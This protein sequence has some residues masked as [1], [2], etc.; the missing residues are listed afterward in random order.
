VA[1]GIRVRPDRRMKSFGLRWM[2]A[3]IPNEW[4]FHVN[5]R[6]SSFLGDNN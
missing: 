3:I 2:K 4:R 5:R 1:G 6:I